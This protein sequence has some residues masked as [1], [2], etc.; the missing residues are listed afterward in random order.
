MLTIA[1]EGMRFYAYH[2]FYEEE[3][4]VGNEYQ[5]DVYLETI[6]HKHGN[7]PIPEDDIQTTI[8]YETIYH[9]CKLEMKKPARLLETLAQHILKKIKSQY[10][11]PLEISENGEALPY[12]VEL[13]SVR[14]RVSKF[15]PPL[16]GRIA[17]AYIEV[18]G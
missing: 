2:G 12:H 13:K 4:I 3:Q 6:L 17:R 9:I 1:L 7:Q 15:N 18:Q 5:V 8:S 11:N 16:G 10:K 14:V